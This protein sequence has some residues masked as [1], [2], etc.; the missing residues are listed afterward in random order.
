MLLQPR[1]LVTI[2]LHNWIGHL[3][4]IL[5]TIIGGGAPDW[6]ST[7]T[8]Q[9]DTTLLTPVALTTT[10]STGRYIL[11][12]PPLVTIMSTSLEANGSFTIVTQVVANPSTSGEQLT[13][14]SRLV[15]SHM[16]NIGD[17]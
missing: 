13:T 7:I 17:C 6:T 2:P 16:I 8:T 10:D 1:P 4:T 3:S 9:P 14:K 11:T 12:T 15:N 5:V